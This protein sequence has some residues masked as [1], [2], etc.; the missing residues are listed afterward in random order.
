[1]CHVNGTLVD[2]Q[3]EVADGI[4]TMADDRLWLDDVQQQEADGR[5][6]EHDGS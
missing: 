6:L 2:V 5:Q 4:L 1:M 3:L